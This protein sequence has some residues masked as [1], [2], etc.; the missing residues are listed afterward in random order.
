MAQYRRGGRA[1]KG[2]SHDGT[3]WGDVTRGVLT[4]R[5]HHLKVAVTQECGWMRPRADTGPLK[6]NLKRSVLIPASD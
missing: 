1:L 5:W 3:E 2:C 6:S 4:R